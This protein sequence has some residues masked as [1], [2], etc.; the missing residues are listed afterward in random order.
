MGKKGKGVSKMG[1]AI[2]LF[3]QTMHEPAKKK[4]RTARRKTD[5][6]NALTPEEI[7]EI[8]DTSKNERGLGNITLKD[9]FGEE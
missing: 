2:P 8:N 3:P 6:L 5:R 7:R 9:I 1:I 4:I